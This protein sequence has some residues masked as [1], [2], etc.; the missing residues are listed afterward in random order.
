[1]LFKYGKHSHMDG[2]YETI[3]RDTRDTRLFGY[4]HLNHIQRA[5]VE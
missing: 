4:Y 1:M 2:G 3:T 5:L